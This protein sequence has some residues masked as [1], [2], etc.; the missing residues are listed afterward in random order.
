MININLVK[1]RYSRMLDSEIIAL[2]EDS[3]Q[4]TNEAFYLL[5]QEFRK[6]NLDKAILLAG[7]DE[8]I[9]E[10]KEK[11]RNNIAIEREKFE[12]AIWTYALNEKYKD[13][14]D[15]EIQLGLMERGLTYED[16][17]EVTE[18]LEELSKL[19]ISES[20]DNMTYGAVCFLGGIVLTG[21]SLMIL[22]NGPYLIF[23]GAILVGGIRYIIC[24]NRKYRYRIILNNVR[25]EVE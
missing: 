3:T 2:A 4:L 13:L 10:K 1:E 5:K 14:D 17:K 25:K 8:R 21:I 15:D 6:R 20:N 22:T 19:L 12:N 11:V 24:N 23:L 18:F 7:M 16:A 9:E